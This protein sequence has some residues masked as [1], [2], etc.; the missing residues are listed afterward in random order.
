M[1]LITSIK[2]LFLIL[3]NTIAADGNAILSFNCA[4][5]QFFNSKWLSLR[6]FFYVCYPDRVAFMGE[7]VS[8]ICQVTNSYTQVWIKP[9][10]VLYILYFQILSYESSS[11]ICIPIGAI[12]KKINVQSFFYMPVLDK[13]I[14]F[15]DNT[16]CMEIFAHVLYVPI[17]IRRYFNMAI[18]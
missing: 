3:V 10:M 8:L 2:T 4:S 9:H 7:S 17:A 14:I 5:L 13:W 15:F 12:V 1:A 6:I 16:V 11:C 18:F